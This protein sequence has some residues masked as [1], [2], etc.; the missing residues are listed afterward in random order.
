VGVRAAG[1]GLPRPPSRSSL[2]LGQ[3]DGLWLPAVATNPEAVQ[4]ERATPRGLSAAVLS[5]L[6]NPTTSLVA[7]SGDD[8]ALLSFIELAH[9]DISYNVQVMAPDPNPSSA[10]SHVG[11][12]TP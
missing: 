9:P 1:C 12:L 6:G 7:G 2:S 5:R 10:R 8:T 4:L 3:S 11:G